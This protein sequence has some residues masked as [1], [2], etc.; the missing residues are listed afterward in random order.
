ME[1]KSPSVI[2]VGFKGGALKK[3]GA[4]SKRAKSEDRKMSAHGQGTGTGQGTAHSQGTGNGQRAG[5]VPGH[6]SVFLTER[7]GT[8]GATDGERP[9]DK[10]LRAETLTDNEGIF[11]VPNYISGVPKTVP[12]SP[13]KLFVLLCCIQIKLL[14]GSIMDKCNVFVLFCFCLHLDLKEG[15]NVKL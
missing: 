2:Q 9:N 14:K 15:S 4:Y 3:Q 5:Q 7:I 11:V 6:G 8:G 13:R 10:N 1:E 12:L